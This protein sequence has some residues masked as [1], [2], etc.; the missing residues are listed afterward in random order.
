MHFSGFA[1]LSGAFLQVPEGG[2][3]AVIGPN[4][5]GKTT[6]FNCISGHLRPTRGRIRYGGREIVGTP[7][8]RLSRA[9]IARSFQ[10][11]NVFPRLSVFDN[12]H[13]AV[14]ASD[15]R[16]ANLWTPARA[17][18][19][20]RTWELLE[21]VGLAGRAGQAAASLGHG[22]R[23]LLEIAIALA[24]R[25]RLMLLDEPTAGM[26]PEERAHITG[27]IQ[28]LHRSEG[29]TVLFTEHDIDVVFGIARSIMVL[30]R[31][32]TLVQGSPEAVRAHPEVQSAYLG[33]PV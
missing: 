27:L 12:V 5:A 28:A 32:R 1:A 11:T 33:E 22:D 14:L 19:S 8:H 13:V 16:S 7:P 30:H 26:S 29:L 31:G 15:G 24:T 4:G 25:P 2:I 10:L 18:S 21:R 9:G 20:A 17:Q 6:L 23:K 3:V